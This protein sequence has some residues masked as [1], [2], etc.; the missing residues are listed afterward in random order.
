[1][2]AQYIEYFRDSCALGWQLSSES[3]TLGGSLLFHYKIM[4]CD[5]IH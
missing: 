4:S 5:Y 2:S 3:R 1:M